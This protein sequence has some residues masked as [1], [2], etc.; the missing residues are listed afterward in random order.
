[1]EAVLVVVLVA[2][3]SGEVARVVHCVVEIEQT[4]VAVTVCCCHQFAS[5]ICDAIHGLS[6][7]RQPW[8]AMQ[9]HTRGNKA[10]GH[11]SCQIRFD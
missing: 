9:G 4:E 1:M 7:P 5:C 8:V 2:C 11:L 6:V 10:R 3:V